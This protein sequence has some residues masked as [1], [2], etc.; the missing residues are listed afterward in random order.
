MAD[1]L[2]NAEKLKAHYAWWRVAGD[3]DMADTF[4][5]IVDS[6]PTVESTKRGRWIKVGDSSWECSICHEVSCCN[7][8]Y[9]VDCGADMREVEE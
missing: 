3:A 6:Q 2:I 7:G 4:D 1:R 9:C 5:A 8:N